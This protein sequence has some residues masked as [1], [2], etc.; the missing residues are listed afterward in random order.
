MFNWHAMSRR[1]KIT[2][3][4]AMALAA[5]YLWLAIIGQLLHPEAAPICTQAVAAWLACGVGML[6]GLLFDPINWVIEGFVFAAVWH[7]LPAR[8]PES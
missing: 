3:C 2:V 7:A 8:P 6:P 1:V 5:G 4:G